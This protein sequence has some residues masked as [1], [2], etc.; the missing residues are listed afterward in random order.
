[1]WRHSKKVAICKPRR[2]A[3]GDTGSANT[4]IWDIQPPE[5]WEKKFLLFKQLSLWCFVQAA[6]TNEYR[7]ETE[8]VSRSTMS[9]SFATLWTIACQAPLFMEF[10]RQEYWSGLPFPSP[11]IFWTQGSNLG[12]PHCGH[13]LYCLN[14]QGSPP[15]GNPW[16]KK[17]KRLREHNKSIL[18]K[19]TKS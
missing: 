11:G 18:R 14:H 5:L 16:I 9:D 15:E 10:S 1:M 3:S 6:L 8:S 13:I 7:G 17:K 4:L 19:D 12:L 2:E